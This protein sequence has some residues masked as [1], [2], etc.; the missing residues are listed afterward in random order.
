M[1]SKLEKILSEKRKEITRLKTKTDI[2]RYGM[3]PDPVRDF[4]KAV[5]PDKEPVLITEI[6]FASPSAGMIRAHED[7]LAIAQC[8]EQAG[9]AAISFLTDRI[10]FEG[11]LEWLPKVKAA[12]SL[13]V[14]RKDFI[15]DE[16]QVR[17]SRAFGADAVLLI[18]RILSG[19]QLQELLQAVREA[20]LAA[21]TEVHN[22]AELEQALE[23]GADLIGINNRNLDTFAVDLETTLELAPLVPA[24]FGPVSESGIY[25]AEDIRLLAQSGVKAFLIGTALMQ[26]EDR[27]AKIK[28][29][30]RARENVRT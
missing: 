22:R 26:A 7:P 8:Y 4:K 28:E 27:M 23:C 17:E 11:N 29:L 30:L 14:L 15:L 19:A 9:A 20:G 18:V 12:V 10:F 6:K 2:A 5:L 3:Y 13:P 24:R 21:L 1:H 16:I 25:S